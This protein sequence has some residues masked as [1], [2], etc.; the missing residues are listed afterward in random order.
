MR[1]GCALWHEAQWHDSRATCEPA[2]AAVWS[3]R[4]ISMLTL[5]AHLS[6]DILNPRRTTRAPAGAPAR[7]VTHVVSPSR[8]RDVDVF[9][10][11]GPSRRHLQNVFKPAACERTL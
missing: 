7:P 9:R 3:R 6:L 2:L 1:V 11:R 5:L 10:F 4:S 8:V